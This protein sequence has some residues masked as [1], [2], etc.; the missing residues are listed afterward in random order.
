MRLPDRLGIVQGSLLLFAAALIGRAGYVQLYRGHYWSTVGQRQQYASSKLSAS[1]GE[2][3]DEDGSTLAESRE[4]TRIAVA[5][6]DVNN[7]AAL[8]RTLRQAHADPQWIARVLDRKRRWVDIPQLFLPA[9]IAP[10]LALRGVHATPAMDRVDGTSP[11][12]NRVV[13]RVDASG[14]PLDGIELMLDDVL[15]GDTGSV[16]VARDKSG[17]A[18]E[19]PSDGTGPHSG[20]TVVLTINRS[21]QDICERA[22]ANAVD[23]LHATGGDIV[24]MNPQTG[25]VLALASQRTDPRAVANTSVS[26]PYE[27]GSTVKPFVAAKLLSLGRARPDEVMNT[28]GGHYVLDGRK[29]DDAEEHQPMMTLS[30]VIQH[31]SN[32]GIVLFGE[33]LTPREKY[34]LFRDVGFGTP[35]TI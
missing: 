29:I 4:L 23:S 20:N 8:A 33:R 26:E 15:R 31:S 11:G 7:P 13:G 12:M 30:E 5:P 35:T 28:F 34:E 14:K 21:L 3:V 32:V 18:L 6:R 19:A 1:R 10:A 25:D 17:H 16:R 9:D 2:I 27:P 22:L 24:V